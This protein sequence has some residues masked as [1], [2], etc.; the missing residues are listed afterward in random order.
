[1]FGMEHNWLALG[2]LEDCVYWQS[3]ETACGY[4]NWSIEF[5]SPGQGISS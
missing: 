5:V 1:M 2:S 3:S 4:M